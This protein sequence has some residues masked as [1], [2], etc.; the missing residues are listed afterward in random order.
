MH[1]HFRAS[2]PANNPRASGMRHV[3]SVA[4]ACLLVAGVMT[5]QATAAPRVIASAKTVTT[6]RVVLTEY[7]FA[8]SR[9]SVPVGTVVF[10]LVNKGQL[11]HNMAYTGPVIYKKAPLVSPGSTYRFTV[12]F[13]KAGTYRFVCTP[14]FKLG[15]SGSITVK[16]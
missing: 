10:L 3:F 14:H 6:V 4:A 11:P 2:T 16:K 7:H 12:V 15:M 9:K 5:S 1:S 8:L 13:K